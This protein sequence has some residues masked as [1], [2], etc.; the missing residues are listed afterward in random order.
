MIIIEIKWVLK[1]TPNEKRLQF[2]GVL[3]L[4]FK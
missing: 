4:I 1:T 2:D 3:W